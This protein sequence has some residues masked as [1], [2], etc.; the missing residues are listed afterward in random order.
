MESDSMRLN[1]QIFSRVLKNLPRR[2]MQLLPALL[3]LQGTL[4]DLSE[5]GLI[6]IAAHLCVSRSEVERVYAAFSGNRRWPL[7]KELVRVCTGPSCRAAG[8]S[9]NTV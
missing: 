5:D 3:L 1:E 4:G 6:P 9:G 7:D 2:R 8:S